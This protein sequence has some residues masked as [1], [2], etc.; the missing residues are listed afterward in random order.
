MPCDTTYDQSNLD[1][2]I[3][4]FCKIDQTWN[5]YPDI[6]NIII[7]G[8]FNTHMARTNSLHTSALSD[9]VAQHGLVM[10][11]DCIDGKVIFTYE[12]FVSGSKSI[13]LGA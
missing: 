7:G 6:V 3:D 11:S 5:A 12:N 1:T 9:F 2:Y 10:C 8:D 13:L 4:V